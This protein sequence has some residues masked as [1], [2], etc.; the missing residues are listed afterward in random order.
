L[1]ANSTHPES[2][3]GHARWFRS[4]GRTLKDQTAVA[5]KEVA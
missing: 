2:K 3:N 1:F 5:T 4:I